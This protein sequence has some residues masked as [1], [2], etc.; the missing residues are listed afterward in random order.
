M[1]V[2]MFIVIFPVA[3]TA[4]IANG[5]FNATPMRCTALPLRP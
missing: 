2:L 1:T 5:Q 4:T 3:V